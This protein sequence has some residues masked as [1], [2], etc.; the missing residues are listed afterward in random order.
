MPLNWASGTV[1]SLGT[2]KQLNFLLSVFLDLIY[3]QNGDSCTATYW[4]SAV[5]YGCVCHRL[6]E[7][8]IQLKA[9]LYAAMSNIFYADTVDEWLSVNVDPVMNK[10]ARIVNVA[11]QQ[12]QLGGQVKAAS[13]AVAAVTTNASVTQARADA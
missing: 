9:E 4:N 5:L 3:Y 12:I 6:L 7:S 1:N 13:V 2:S 8:A 11:S 10:L